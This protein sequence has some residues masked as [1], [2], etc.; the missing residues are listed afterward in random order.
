MNEP[1]IDG[2]CGVCHK[3][4][5]PEVCLGEHVGEGGGVV[6]MKTVVMS[7]FAQC[8]IISA[9]NASGKSYT[10]VR[11]RMMAGIIYCIDLWYTK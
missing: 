7:V 8:T 5:A 10:G 11:A 2:F 1:F 9:Q 6:D 3:H 4:S